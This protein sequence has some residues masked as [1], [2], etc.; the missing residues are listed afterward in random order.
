M[1]LV[2]RVLPPDPY[3]SLDRYIRAGVISGG[4]VPKVKA[5]VSALKDVKQVRI[6]DLVGLR[7]DTGTRF[8]KG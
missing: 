3:E 5:A 4:M 8:L 6:T 1:T 2:H 7:A